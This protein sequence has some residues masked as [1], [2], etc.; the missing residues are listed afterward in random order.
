MVFCYSNL[1]I[2]IQHMLILRCLLYIKQEVGYTIIELGES[3][4]CWYEFGSH[5]KS[6]VTFKTKLKLNCISLVCTPGIITLCREINGIGQLCL[7]SN[8]LKKK[9]TPSFVCSFLS[10]LGFEHNDSFILLLTSRYN[11]SVK[12]SYCF[13]FLSSVSQI[14]RTKIKKLL[15]E[16]Q[17]TELLN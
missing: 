16:V 6:S 8:V 15:Y 17:V 1:S 2:L 12:Y 10:L 3:W 11:P 5:Q 4:Y 7:L 9:L 13:S 14:S